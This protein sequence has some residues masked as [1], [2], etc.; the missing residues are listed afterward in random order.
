MAGV[1]TGLAKLGLKLDKRKA[2]VEFLRQNWRTSSTVPQCTAVTVRGVSNHWRPKSRFSTDGAGIARASLVSM[3]MWYAP[4]FICDART[5]R[6]SSR[7]CFRPPRERTVL[8]RASLRRLPALQPRNRLRLSSAVPIGTS[9]YP[10]PDRPF[11]IQ[12]DPPFPGIVP[13]PPKVEIIVRGLRAKIVSRNILD[14]QTD[15]LK[16]FRL[17]RIEPALQTSVNG[18]RMTAVDR[19]G[20]NFLIRLAEG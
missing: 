2:S 7:E 14:V 16:S 19:R 1:Q 11:L 8:I 6:N 20:K 3:S 12:N 15:W 5:F 18:R 17:P 9:N 4:P 13:E 10:M